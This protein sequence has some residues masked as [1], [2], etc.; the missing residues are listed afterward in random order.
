MC[1]DVLL[2]LFY[3]TVSAGDILMLV[4]VTGKDVGQL[5]PLN[6]HSNFNFPKFCVLIPWCKIFS[7]VC[8]LETPTQLPTFFRGQN[9]GMMSRYLLVLTFSLCYEDF[10]A[11]KLLLLFEHNIHHSHR[12]QH[13]TSSRQEYHRRMNSQIIHITTASQPPKQSVF[14]ATQ[15]IQTN[16]AS[17]ESPSLQSP[18]LE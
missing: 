17:F 2:L 4:T 5:Q 18:P 3:D 13:F 14:L 8:C 12:S 1:F 15:T 10:F 9:L 11:K 16:I 6:S 7:S